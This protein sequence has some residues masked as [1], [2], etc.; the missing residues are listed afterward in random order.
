MPD[1][2]IALGGPDQYGKFSAMLITPIPAPQIPQRV[3]KIRYLDELESLKQEWGVD[4][5][6]GD[7]LLKIQPRPQ[8]D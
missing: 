6:R 7:G 4:E 3:S 5:V 1:E 2:Y 8:D